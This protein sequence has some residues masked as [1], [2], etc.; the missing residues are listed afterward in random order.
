MSMT[1]TPMTP[2]GKKQLEERLKQ[3]KSVERPQNIAAIEEARNHGDLSENAEYDAAKERQ[4]QISTQIQEIEHKLSLAH[5]IDPS[6]IDSDKIVFGATVTLRN[7]ENDKEATYTIVGVDEADLK[8]GK[9]SIE[10]PIARALIG[11]Q[12]DDE[13]KVRTPKGIIEYEV[14]NLEYC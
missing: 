12:L 6:S 11:K 2:N 4:L 3:L 7:L 13:V 9:I 10:S 8:H 5:V 1:R 14:I